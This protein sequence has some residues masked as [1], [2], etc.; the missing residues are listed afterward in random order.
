M[1]Y[2]RHAQ[3]PSHHLAHAP[4][5]GRLVFPRWIHVRLS[6][7]ARWSTAESSP[8]RPSAAS[9]ISAIVFSNERRRLLGEPIVVP[10]LGGRPC[11]P[12]GGTPVS[13]GGGPAERPE[14]RRRTPGMSDAPSSA[15][16]ASSGSISVGGRCSFS[17]SSFRLRGVI[18]IVL[19]EN[20][21]GALTRPQSCDLHS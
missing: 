19:G 5:L 18:A 13:T 14:P 2:S 12:P 8:P 17:M 4:Y 6:S 7:S 3:V 20:A 21:H 9:R 11:R 10:R 1:R 15:N 16:S